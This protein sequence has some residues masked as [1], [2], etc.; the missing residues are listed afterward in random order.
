MEKHQITERELFRLTEVVLN[1]MF[2]HG[3]LDS[4]E[5]GVEEFV[6]EII[7]KAA[8]QIDLIKTKETISSEHNSSD[9]K[10]NHY[11]HI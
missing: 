4:E 6:E 3:L 10:F 1:S 5:E 2:A 8:D 9:V 7:T 11:I